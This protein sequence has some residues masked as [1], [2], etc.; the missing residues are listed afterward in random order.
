MLFGYPGNIASS[1]GQP[2]AVDKSALMSVAANCSR[3]V[4]GM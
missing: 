1:M 4:Y 3:P 2:R